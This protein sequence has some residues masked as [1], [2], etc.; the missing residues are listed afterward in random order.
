M[1]R[2]T[3]VLA[4]TF[5]LLLGLISPLALA[6]EDGATFSDVRIMQV[7]AGR[8]DEF[9]ELI[10]RVTA[11]LGSAGRPPMTVW[12]EVRGNLANY[13]LVTPRGAFGDFDDDPGPPIAAGPWA[14]LITRLVDVVESQ[15]RILV[16]NY[17]DLSIPAEEGSEPAEFMRLRLREIAWGGNAAYIE[18]LEDDLLPALADA[19]VQGIGYS[20]IVEG[21][22]PRIWVTA[23]EFNSWAE[24]DEPGALADLSA[25][26]IQQIVSTGN[27]LTLS[28]E[29]IVLRRREDLM[30]Q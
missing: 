22:S 25:R 15:R 18:W 30:A 23:R 6:Q 7:K 16:R 8:A 19:G 3:T 27:E 26:E 10:A 28:G 29:N 20:R 24:L 1:N 4:V 17:P 9:Q 11:A 21:D 12:Q 13:H 14:N 2:S 5:S